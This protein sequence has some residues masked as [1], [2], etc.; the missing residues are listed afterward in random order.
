MRNPRTT[1]LA[2]ALALPVAACGAGD[3]A[4]KS[5]VVTAAAPDDPFVDPAVDPAGTHA[6]R[7]ITHPA[8]CTP[9]ADGAPDKEPQAARAAVQAVLSDPQHPLHRL[10]L[11]LVHSRNDGDRVEFFGL[12]QDP[13][14]TYRVL[15]VVARDTGEWTVV[16]QH[17]CAA[18]AWPAGVPT[19]GPPGTG[20]EGTGD[21]RDVEGGEFGVEPREA[22]Q[23]L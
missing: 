11:R 12:E 9:A 4:E 14:S 2:L 15:F 7:G 17:P 16:R 1:L 22:V 6:D 19:P 18:R 10:D 20:F 8:G 13:A 3:S 5:E 23:G 21:V